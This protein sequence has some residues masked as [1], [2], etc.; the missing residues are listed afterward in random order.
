MSFTP[1][2]LTLFLLILMVAQAPL[3]V[4]VRPVPRMLPGLCRPRIALLGGMSGGSCRDSRLSQGKA[5][6]WSPCVCQ[7]MPLP[8]SCS[9]WCMRC[10][11][12]GNLSL[13]LVPTLGQGG[14]SA[15][16]H[17]CCAPSALLL[18]RNLIQDHFSSAFP[19]HLDGEWEPRT[20]VHRPRELLHSLARWDHPAVWF[21]FNVK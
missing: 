13:Q 18:C 14:V 3:T 12:A 1:L 4:V 16:H 15:Q 17:G 9:S 8:P 10:G 21:Y 5:P 11:T 6:P 20:D 2:F 19:P 7:R